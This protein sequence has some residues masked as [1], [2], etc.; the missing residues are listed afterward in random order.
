MAMVL[1]N[2]SLK[3]YLRDKQEKRKTSKAA[4]NRQATSLSP[5]RRPKLSVTKKAVKR[6]RANLIGDSYQDK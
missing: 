5:L 6:G 2:A 3:V 4:G 1:L